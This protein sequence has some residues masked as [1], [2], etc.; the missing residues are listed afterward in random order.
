VLADIFATYNI[1]IT[2]S[3]HI[4]KKI[5]IQEINKMT[6]YQK[7]EQAIIRWNNDG[8]ET[9]GTLTREILKII[10]DEKAKEHIQKDDHNK[11]SQQN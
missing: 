3:V 2:P 10:E 9:A 7:I 6:V 1:S 4:V 11:G 5:T 8:T